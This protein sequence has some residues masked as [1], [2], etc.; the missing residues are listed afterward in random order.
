MA[1][2]PMRTQHSDGQRGGRDDGA[3][4]PCACAWPK[5]GAISVRTLALCI[6]ICVSSPP[7]SARTSARPA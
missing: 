5:G 4:H 2:Y 1:Y 7:V 6:E 3:D